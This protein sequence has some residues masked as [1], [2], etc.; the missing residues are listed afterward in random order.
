MPAKNWSHIDHLVLCLHAI[1]L[2]PM[3]PLIK[4]GSLTI[5]IHDHKALQLSKIKQEWADN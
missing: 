5:I 1:H 4:Y 2:D 3:H